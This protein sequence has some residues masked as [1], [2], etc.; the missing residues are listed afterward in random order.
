MPIIEKQEDGGRERRKE[1]GERRGIGRRGG[2]GGREGG[3]HVFLAHHCV[4]TEEECCRSKEL[5]QS[6]PLIVADAN[7]HT[8]ERLPNAI[9]I[10]SLYRAR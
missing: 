10:D 1:G 6:F 5:W 8:L 9:C 3:W 4:N 7:F 2:G